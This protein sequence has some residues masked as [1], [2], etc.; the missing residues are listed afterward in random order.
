MAAQPRA[1][2]AA[3]VADPYLAALAM[4]TSLA[5]RVALAD[6]LAAIAGHS[7]ADNGAEV[8][9]KV[10]GVLLTAVT[11]AMSP[12]DRRTYAAALSAV[13]SR[14]KPLWRVLRTS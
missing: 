12:S 14:L 6:G 5:E 4:A 1:D 2:Q 9:W 10:A 13:T 3:A 8:C 11:E 7:S